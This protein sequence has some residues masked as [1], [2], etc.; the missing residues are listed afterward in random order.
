M[1]IR[2]VA[3]DQV[4]LLLTV[5]G[6]ASVVGLKHLNH[7]PSAFVRIVV[8]IVIT[9]IATPSAPRRSG[10]RVR[11]AHRGRLS[12]PRRIALDSKPDPMAAHP[13][14]QQPWYSQGQPAPP[15]DNAATP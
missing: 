3:C 1:A 4:A 14:P 12:R 13:S 8:L 10:L 9:Q 6:G 11:S 15:A 7:S 5:P 2:Q